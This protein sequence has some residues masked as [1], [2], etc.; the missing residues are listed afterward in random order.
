[1]ASLKWSRRA[2]RLFSHDS[3]RSLAV[4]LLF[5][6]PMIVVCGLSLN[7]SKSS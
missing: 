2:S 1:M 3:S 7:G 4:M 5:G 6:T